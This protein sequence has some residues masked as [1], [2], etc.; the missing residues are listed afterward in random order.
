MSNLILKG[1]VTANFGEYLP[2]PYINRIYLGTDDNNQVTVRVDLQVYLLATEMMDVTSLV[3]QLEDIEYFWWVT[4]G[5]TNDPEDIING[6]V[7]IWEAAYGFGP[8][9]YDGWLGGQAIKLSDFVTT[10]DAADLGS[11]TI[12]DYEILYDEAGNR[13]LKFVYESPPLSLNISS[14]DQTFYV[15]AWSTPEQFENWTTYNTDD[16]TTW[17]TFLESETSDVAYEMIMRDGVIGGEDEIA[18][19]DE[20]DAVYAGA[21]LQSITSQ[22]YDSS[23]ITNEEII[24]SFQTLTAQYQDAGTS[25]SSLQNVLNSISLILKTGEIAVDLLPQ[26]SEYGKAFPSKTSAT[27]IGQLYLQYI[28]K[29]ALANQA[30]V[31]GG[32]IIKKSIRGAS[33]VLDERGYGFI[34]Y[35]PPIPVAC[36]SEDVCINCEFLY[37]KLLL[38]RMCF[39]GEYTTITDVEAIDV[40]EDISDVAWGA[41]YGWFFFDYDKAFYYTAGISQVYDVERLVKFVG[42]HG[43]LDGGASFPSESLRGQELVNGIF[44]LYKVKISRYV[45][46]NKKMSMYTYYTYENEDSPGYPVIRYNVWDG[47]YDAD[48]DYLSTDGGLNTIQDSTC[49][50]NSYLHLRN[51]DFPQHGGTDDDGNITYGQLRDYGTGY[52]GLPGLRIM[53]FEFQDIMGYFE[54]L[55]A[56]EDPDTGF[57]VAGEDADKGEYQMEIH[58]ADYSSAVVSEL[59]TKY[60]SYK[61]K[62]NDYYAEASEPCSYNNIDGSFNQYF[63]DSQ[64]ALYADTP[65]E[66]PWIVCPSA[67]ISYMD[68]IQGTYEDDEDGK[69]AT[70]LNIM[71]NIA[72]T[73]GNLYALESFINAVDSLEVPS[74]S[75]MSDGY[76][77]YYCNFD[78]A[79]HQSVAWQVAPIDADDSSTVCDYLGGVA[80]D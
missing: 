19:M 63:I 1:D 28:D 45:G 32:R 22:Y 3:G 57:P 43:D 39:P 5:T 10:L 26:L 40:L 35:A 51:F 12:P 53:A 18:Y 30:L 74:A 9:A 23:G 77:Y 14:M 50:A 44:Q 47:N 41:N 6:E 68:L 34:P 79:D 64:E 27:T 42:T 67:F 2:T 33:K 25:D 36:N 17:Q 58:M 62:L 69:T 54:Q 8:T 46:D 21:T 29:V 24:N 75:G 52:V 61:T 70:A 55:G 65:E 60:E 73:T 72:P 71:N 15:F 16:E 20:N 66:A 7:N 4:R 13:V 48:E 49:T 59:Y 78:I 38:T 31:T 76:R 37:N 80:N 11:V 56:D